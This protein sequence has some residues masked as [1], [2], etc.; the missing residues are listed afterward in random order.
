MVT[1]TFIATCF[2]WK[3]YTTALQMW[4]WCRERSPSRRQ[5]SLHE[6]FVKNI[7]K[8]I[9]ITITLHY[10]KIFYCISFC[11]FINSWGRLRQLLWT[12]SD[13]ALEIM[14]FW[15]WYLVWISKNHTKNIKYIYLPTMLTT[16]FVIFRNWI[17][18]I[19]WIRTKRSAKTFAF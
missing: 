2:S 17:V 18:N 6:H 8:T 13:C 19:N 9:W 12:F 3:N 10:I 15:N 16:K 7:P 14:Y 1:G 11:E 5:H 4:A